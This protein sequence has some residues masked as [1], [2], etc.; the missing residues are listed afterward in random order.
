MQSNGTISNVII[1][2]I[3]LHNQ[4]QTFSCYAFTIK[5]FHRQ[6]MSPADLPLLAR[7]GVALV[8]LVSLV[9]NCPS[10]LNPLRATTGS[11]SCGKN[12]H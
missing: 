3:D 2:G 8:A 7:H 12:L 4:G 5:H 11:R 1:R 9:D 10:H 6:R